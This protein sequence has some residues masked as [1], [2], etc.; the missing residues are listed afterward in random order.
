MCR[1]ATGVGAVTR[2]SLPPNKHQ[3]MEAVI[4]R[5]HCYDNTEKGGSPRHS[6][7]DDACPARLT[8]RTE[9]QNLEEKRPK[10]GLP[11]WQLKKTLPVLITGVGFGLVRHRAAPWAAKWREE[12]AVA[13]IRGPRRMPK[14]VGGRSGKASPWVAEVTDRGRVKPPSAKGRVPLPWLSRRV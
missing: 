11:S 9:L 3:H 14:K 4:W 7:D 2:R 1:R 13:P 8:S 10:E 5:R 12:S 6:W